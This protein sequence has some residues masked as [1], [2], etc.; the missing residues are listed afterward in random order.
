VILGWGSAFQSEADPDPD[1]DG[2]PDPISNSTHVGKSDCDNFYLQQTQFTLFYLSLRQRCIN[3]QY[4]G[5]YI[6]IF[7]E[8][9][10]LA[11]YIG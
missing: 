9:E 6:E 7:C 4:F 10:Q 5:Q 8:K 3:F 2:D 11:F 1:P